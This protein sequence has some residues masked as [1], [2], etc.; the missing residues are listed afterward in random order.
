MSKSNLENFISKHFPKLSVFILLTNQEIQEEFSSMASLAQAGLE[1]QNDGN[2][3]RKTL[4]EIEKLISKS[5]QKTVEKPS[6]EA[7]QAVEDAIVTAEKSTEDAKATTGFA[8]V[9]KQFKAAVSALTTECEMEYIEAIQICLSFPEF[10][11][12]EHY[13][14]LKDFVGTEMKLDTSKDKDQY[15]LN[16]SLSQR[17]GKYLPKRIRIL[18]KG[19]KPGLQNNLLRLLGKGLN[20]QDEIE[21]W[22]S[23][24]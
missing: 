4:D 10:Q 5:K 13:A 3:A 8:K 24:S 9:L 1:Y 12:S 15:K 7:L 18:Y 19:T 20:V 22:V 11:T 6:G 21:K 14:Q 16:G 23:E 2:D 17:R